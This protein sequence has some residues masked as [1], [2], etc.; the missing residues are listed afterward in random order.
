[1]SL[2]SR[3]RSLHLHQPIARSAAL[4]VLSLIGRS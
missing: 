3:G 1:M 4:M 2:E